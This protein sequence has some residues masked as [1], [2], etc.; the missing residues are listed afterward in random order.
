MI[1]KILK[2][3]G[4]SNERQVKRYQGMVNRV[5]ALEEEDDRSLRR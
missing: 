2:V 5:N 4:D 3:L 1:G